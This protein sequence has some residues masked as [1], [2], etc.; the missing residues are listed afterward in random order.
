MSDLLDTD[1]GAVVISGASGIFHL[2]EIGR[3]LV[4]FANNGIWA[5]S[6]GESS[7]KA[8]EYSVYKVSDYTALNS[9]VIY[10]IPNAVTFVSQSGIMLMSTD[11]VTLSPSVNNITL[12]SV[13]ELF[14]SF[15]GDDLSKTKIS[16]EAKKAKV[17]YL[18]GDTL[19][20][21]DTTLQA[22]YKHK[23]PTGSVAL[24]HTDEEQVI[25]EQSTV[26]HLGIDVTNDS[27]VVTLSTDSV[28]SV[29]PQVMVTYGADD[30]SYKFCTFSDTDYIDFK[31]TADESDYESY[32]I[33]QPLTFDNAVSKKRLKQLSC[34][35]TKTETGYSEN[36]EGGLEYVK[37]SSCKLQIGWDMPT[38]NSYASDPRNMW[39]R[40]Y[41]LYRLSRY[42]SK[43]LG[44]VPA[45]ALES[46]MTRTS[47]RGTGRTISMRFSSPSGYDC[48]LLGW[49][50]D[51]LAN[52]RNK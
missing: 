17:N 23:L 32:F 10:N 21:L 13:Q 11:Q 14:S 20:V 43:S 12:N 50:V 22:W 16:F 5:I 33:T 28:V 48:R 18:I 2:T 15:S 51:M 19:L 31:G 38:S 52:T 35:F 45:N 1:G 41:E 24:Y 34:F 49:S 42:E 44:E 47:V 40:E 25:T 3:N 36:E 26:T 4:V 8:T 7:F 39:S 6:G 27:E 29:V 30:G 9:T 37:P 46:L